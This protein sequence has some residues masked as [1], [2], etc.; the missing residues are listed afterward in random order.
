[1]HASACMK[2]LVPYQI[3]TRSDRTY[4]LNI[5]KRQNFMLLA[6]QSGAKAYL[7]ALIL[8]QKHAGCTRDG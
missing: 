7:L 1:M 8:T 4:L 5:S 2:V 3:V 6:W